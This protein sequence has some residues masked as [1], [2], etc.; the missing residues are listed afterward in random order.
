MFAKQEPTVEISA[1]DEAMAWHSG[2]ARATI[3]ALLQD[4]IKLLEELAM[5]KACMSRGYT[6]GWAPGRQF[7]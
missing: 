5:A 1:V 3:E 7:E 2:D 4:R 6:R